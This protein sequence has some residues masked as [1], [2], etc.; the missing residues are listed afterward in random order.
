MTGAQDTFPQIV[1]FS[2]KF[3]LHKNLR[4]LAFRCAPFEVTR[5]ATTVV[6]MPIIYIFEFAGRAM[7]V[8]GLNPQIRKEPISVTHLQVFSVAPMRTEAKSPNR[9]ECIFAASAI[10]V[11]IP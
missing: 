7:L 3:K 2:D 9:Q 10:S 4:Y 11:R 8:P 6:A 1:I 5:A